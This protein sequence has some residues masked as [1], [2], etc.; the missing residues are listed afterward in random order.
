MVALA[1][2]NSR[3]EAFAQLLTLLVVFIFVLALTYF[4]T[5]WA[6]NMQ[7]T[8]MAG[9][10]I[11]ILETMRVSNTKY[12]QII[13]IGSKCF[14]VAVCKDTMTYLCEINEQEL[15][16]LS[17]S[18]T[19]NTDG[20]GRNERV[21]LQWIRKHRKALAGI[22]VGAGAFFAAISFITYKVMAA[23]ETT[24]SGNNLINIGISTSDGNDMASVL[25]MLLVLTVI[26]LAPSI[27]IMLT[28]FTRIVI[29]L[30]F[31]RAALG[32]QTV[33][34]NQVI[35]GLSL[36]LT[37]F[38]MSPVFTEVY[39]SALKPLSN[40][41]ISVE[42]AYETGVKPLKSFMLKQT[43]TKDLDTFFKIAGYEEG[44]VTSEDDISMT[45]LVPSFIISELRIAF[46]IG[47]LI[48]IPFIIIDMVVSSTLMSMGMMMLPPTTISAPFK[49][50]LFVMA[51]GWNLIIGNLVATFK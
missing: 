42:E 13:K 25:Q 21:M 41:E 19:I 23:E 46:I 14:A 32:T 35:I 2:L 30:H 10:N 16:Y 51:D 17:E 50:L 26:S 43:S 45:V 9:R 24:A 6:G 3:W 20:L 29:V 5:R 7:K 8:K 39:D 36:F 40:N 11:Q 31:T 22:S 18:K 48:Y 49:I 27:L 37:F 34:P 33:P 15:T 12:I 44:S 1:G 47:F 38:V 28:S 4:A